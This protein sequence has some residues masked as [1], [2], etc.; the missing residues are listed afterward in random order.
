VIGCVHECYREK[1]KGAL[2]KAVGVLAYWHK[3]PGDEELFQVAIDNVIAII[4]ATL[5]RSN[6]HG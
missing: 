4:N 2:L 6:Y 5:K 1:E 3:T